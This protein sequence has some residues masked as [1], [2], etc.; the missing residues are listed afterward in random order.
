MIADHPCRAWCGNGVH[1]DLA[2]W[3]EGAWTEDEVRAAWEREGVAY[4]G[5][6]PATEAGDHPDGRQAWLVWWASDEPGAGDMVGVVEIADRLGV[7]RKAI[8]K[9]RMRGL[10]FPEP[11]WTVG[12][13]P[14]WRWETVARWARD[15]GRLT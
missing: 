7:T 11:D 9:W 1:V 14:A 15:T 6:E 12:G 5:H 13:R 3:H 4:L 10:G 2:H 8:D